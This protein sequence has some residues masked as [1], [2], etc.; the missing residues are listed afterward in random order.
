MCGFQEKGF[1]RE[2]RLQEIEHPATGKIQSIVEK[3]LNQIV[4]QV[5]QNCNL[6]CSYC[7][8]SGSYYNRKHSNKQMS[9][10]TALRAVDFFMEHS[11]EIEDATIGFYGGEPLL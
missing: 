3:G 6:R 10:E 4:L 9:K 5:T 8:Y 7:A 2:S 11:S 1:C